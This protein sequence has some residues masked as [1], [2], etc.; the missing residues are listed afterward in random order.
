MTL[1][2]FV[3]LLAVQSGKFF[4]GLGNVELDTFVEVLLEL[5]SSGLLGIAAFIATAW[6]LKIEEL[7]SV[8][9]FIV[10]RF[11]KQPQILKEAEEESSRPTV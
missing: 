3:A 7:E 4:F 8:R 5:V 6:I 1:A 11:L 10:S 9:C 2:S